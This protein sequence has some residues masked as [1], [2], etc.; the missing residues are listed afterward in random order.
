L[1]H[2]YVL[3]EGGGDGDHVEGLAAVVYGHL[4]ALAA[5]GHVPDALVD[6]VLDGVPPPE[7]RALLAVLRVDQVLG[8]QACGRADD[9]AVLAE[10]G[11]VEGDLA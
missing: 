11:H 5:V 7:V 6:H 2:V 8:L 10:G 3:T 4:S 1:L 9:A